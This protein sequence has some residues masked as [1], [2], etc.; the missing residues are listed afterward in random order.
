[1]TT[2]QEVTDTLFRYRKI[3]FQI[4]GWERKFKRGKNGSWKD[5]GEPGEV[6]TPKYTMGGPREGT[7]R[8]EI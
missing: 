3:I 4:S 1:M 2:Q 8:G 7:C 6:P 5:K